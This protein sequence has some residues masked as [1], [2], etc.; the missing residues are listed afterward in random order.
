MTVRNM[1]IRDLKAAGFQ[2]LCTPHCQC[3]I[4]QLRKPSA[5]I[6]SDCEPGR[7]ATNRRGIRTI[8]PV[9]RARRKSKT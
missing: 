6:L 8:E 4:H 2:G 9:R 1:I 5:C 3:T 7:W